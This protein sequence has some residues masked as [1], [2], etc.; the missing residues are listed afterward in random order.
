VLRAR[1]ATFRE[2]KKRGLNDALTTRA[3]RFGECLTTRLD[4]GKPKMIQCAELGASVAIGK[5]ALRREMRCEM[6]RAVATPPGF[7]A[8]EKRTANAQQ[9]STVNSFERSLANHRMP[10]HPTS[11]PAHMR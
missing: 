11:G 5:E 3:E 4:V 9:T 6:R 7:E 10:I 1:S 8:G 2:H